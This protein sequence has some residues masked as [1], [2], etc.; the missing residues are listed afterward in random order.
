MVRAKLGAKFLPVAAAG[1]IIALPVFGLVASPTVSVVALFIF[2]VSFVFL[3]S[4]LVMRAQS[5]LPSLKGVAMSLA[6]FHM[7]VGGAVGTAVNGRLF[8]ATGAYTV[9][10]VTAAST[11][12]ILAIITLRTAPGPGMTSE[13]ESDA[14]S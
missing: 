11:L 3:Q 8:Q 12:L 7:F 14:E 9:A 13:R 1:G 6:S 5:Q 4:T 2:G 10:F